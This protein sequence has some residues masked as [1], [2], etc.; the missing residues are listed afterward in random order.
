MYGPF[1][2]RMDQVP[3]ILPALVVLA[4]AGVEWRHARAV[5]YAALVAAFVLLAGALNWPA[6]SLEELVDVVAAWFAPALLVARCVGVACFL[7]SV[8]RTVRATAAF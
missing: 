2:G 1:N 7:F 3:L 8:V 5:A 4:V 6:L